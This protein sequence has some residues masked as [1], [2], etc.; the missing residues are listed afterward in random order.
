MEWRIWLTVAVSWDLTGCF[1]SWLQTLPQ[2]H[3]Q[4][5]H[6][7]ETTLNSWVLMLILILMLL[8]CAAWRKTSMRLQPFSRFHRSPGSMLKKCS[9]MF[10][11]FRLFYDAKWHLLQQPKNVSELFGQIKEKISLET[12]NWQ[13]LFEVLCKRKSHYNS[14]SCPGLKGTQEKQTKQLGGKS[15]K[16]KSIKKCWIKS[17]LQLLQRKRG[18]PSPTGRTQDFLSSLKT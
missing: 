11:F 4:G 6:H 17:L 12:L 9:E 15:K 10:T 3:S 14:M 5:K 18:P 1:R 16:S 2:K 7:Y 8:V 13:N